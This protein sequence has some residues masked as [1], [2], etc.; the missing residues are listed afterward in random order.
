MI[1]PV[2][3]VIHF[4]NNRGLGLSF[5]VVSCL[6]VFQPILILIIPFKLYFKFHSSIHVYPLFN[7]N[8]RSPTSLPGSLKVKGGEGEGGVSFLRNCGAP[9][10]GVLRDNLALST[11]LIM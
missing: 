4:L 10:V 8:N 6:V 11:E 7:A 3:S 1:Y 9:S 2:D 5:G